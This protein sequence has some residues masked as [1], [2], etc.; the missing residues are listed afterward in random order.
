MYLNFLYLLCILIFLLLCTLLTPYDYMLYVYNFIFDDT[1]NTY[2]TQYNYA[3]QTLDVIS[4]T[5]RNT[6]VNK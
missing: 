1:V 6:T 5:V 4:L 3:I 2:T